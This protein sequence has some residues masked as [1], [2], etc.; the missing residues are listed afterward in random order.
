MRFGLFLP[1]HGAFASTTNIA[2]MAREADQAGFDSVMV[3]DHIVIPWSLTE[4]FSGRFFEAFTTLAYIAGITERVRLGTTVVVLPYRH[5]VTLAKQIATV[6]QLSNGRVLLGAAFGWA[7]EEYDILDVPYRQRG[8]RADEMLEVMTHLWRDGN[9]SFHGEFYD[10]EDF[11]F[12]PR[13]VQQPRPPIWIGGNNERAIERAVK[14]GDGWHPITSAKRAGSVQWTLADLRRLLKLLD[15]RAQLAGRDP[16]T[17]ARSLHSPIAF[18]IDPAP[19]LGDGFGLVGSIDDVRRSIDTAQALG[20][21]H[22]TINCAY[23]IPGRIEEKSIDNV[24]RTFDR[25][26]EDILPEYQQ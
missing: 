3:A 26:V 24:R 19:F 14:Y 8:R 22:I 15:E 16:K 20:L 10:F 2:R 21:E 7:R 17:I 9:N 5:P 4:R 1:H 25:F 13:P 12:D 11:S 23:T 6:D 18:D